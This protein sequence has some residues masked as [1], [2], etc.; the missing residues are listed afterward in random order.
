MRGKGVYSRPY[1]QLKN[2]IPRENNVC[3]EERVLSTIE[4]EQNELE[5]TDQAKREKRIIEEEKLKRIFI[6]NGGKITYFF[7]EARNPKEELVDRL[8]ASVRTRSWQKK[9]DFDLTKE[10]IKKKIDKGICE[11]TGIEFVFIAMFQTIN[12]KYMP[13]KMTRKA[14]PFT[15]SI[16][17][18][19]NRRGYTKDNCQMVVWA[20][21]RAKGADTDDDLYKLAKAIIK[22]RE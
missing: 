12:D 4:K 16:D 19:D 3:R 18:I 9:R 7:R 2:I 13:M 22:F 10:W 11:R 5:T 1:M 14:H 6:R 15:P 20:Y 8:Y 21:N 17:R